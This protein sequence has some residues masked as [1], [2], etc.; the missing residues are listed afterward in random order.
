MVINW[1]QFLFNWHKKNGY[2]N[3]VSGTKTH[4]VSINIRYQSFKC[5]MFIVIIILVLDFEPLA[6]TRLRT[7]YSSGRAPASHVPS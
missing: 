7:R 5:C 2:L 3:Y 4:R 6:G 1:E